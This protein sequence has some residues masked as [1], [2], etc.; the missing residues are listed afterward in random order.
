MRHD[1]A[2]S[3]ALPELV[4]VE[5]VELLDWYDGP[6]DGLALHEGREFWFSAGPDWAP[7]EPRR[8]VLHAITAEQA[9]RVRAEARQFEAFAAAA[10]ADGDAWE[11]AW[12][13]RSTYSEA[14][15]SGWFLA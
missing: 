10:P 14:P 7:G 6:L 8:L 3:D 4:G 9:A 5:I 11:Q 1:H 15:A 13:A 12:D 2:G